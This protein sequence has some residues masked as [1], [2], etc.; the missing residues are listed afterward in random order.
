MPGVNLLPDENG[1]LVFHLERWESSPIVDEYYEGTI[2]RVDGQGQLVTGDRVMILPDL[3]E[4]IPDGYPVFVTGLLQDGQ[5][6]TLNWFHITGGNYPNS[7]YTSQS[8]GGGGGGGGGG[9]ENVNFGAGSFALPNLDQLPTPTPVSAAVNVGEIISG[10][11]GH[12]YVTIHLYA[13][14]SSIPEIN[15][16]TDPTD[17]APFG[18]YYRLEGA[19]AAGLEQYQSL[20]VRIWGQVSGDFE[21]TPIITVERYEA[22]FPGL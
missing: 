16:L 22:Q 3:P 20:P 14:G 4:D 19:A 6:A 2:Q 12:I 17:E 13:D 8:C 11:T 1:N 9:A 7:Y 10:T 18:G 15:I 21:G 5:P